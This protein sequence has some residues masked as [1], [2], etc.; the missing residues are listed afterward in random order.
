MRND[1]NLQSTPPHGLIN[2]SIVWLIVGLCLLLL[3]A[4][5]YGLL[6]WMTRHKKVASLNALGPGKDVPDLAALKA[7]YL[8]FIDQCYQAYL[9]KQFSKRQLHIY[10]SGAVRNFAYEAQHFPAPFLTLNEIKK[11]SYPGMSQ[12]IAQYYP[13]E[14]AQ[15]T[16]GEPLK[17]VEAAKGI[18]QQWV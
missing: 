8:K 18:V 13:E 4:G 2:Y 7:K 17:S 3:I 12:L 5:W 6:W 14:F 1:V 15:L 11:A 16:H 10:L 9:Q